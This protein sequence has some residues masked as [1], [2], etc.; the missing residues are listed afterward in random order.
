MTNDDWGTVILVFLV[1]LTLN[2]VEW[3]D[4]RQQR[5]RRHQAH[6]R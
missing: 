3:Y 1:I 6:R 4:K 5:K 2:L